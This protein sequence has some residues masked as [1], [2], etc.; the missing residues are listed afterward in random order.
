MSFSDKSFLKKL[1]NSNSRVC[2]CTQL[3]SH[4]RLFATPWTPLSWNSPG[5]NTGVGSHSLLQ[6]IFPTQ[7]SKPGLLHCRQIYYHLSLVHTLIPYL[8]QRL[9]LEVLFKSES[10]QGPLNLV[11][12]FFRSLLL[13]NIPNSFPFYLC[14][15][16]AGKN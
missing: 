11:V 16:F 2:V 8:S 5:K 14:Q 13:C 15:L 6:G 4:V 7:G 3:L 12:I 9:I 1:F 10:R